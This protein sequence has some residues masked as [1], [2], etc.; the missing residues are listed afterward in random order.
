VPAVNLMIAYDI[1]L[2]ALETSPSCGWWPWKASG[3]YCGGRSMNQPSLF[4]QPQPTPFERGMEQS[5][6]A[7]RKWTDEQI[8]LVDRAIK[9]VAYFRLYWTVD[10]Y[11]NNCPTISLSTKASVPGSTKP[12]APA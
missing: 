4:D 3:N 6:K 10:K 8:A 2:D 11:G 7:A 5:A 1:Y 9:R 12:H